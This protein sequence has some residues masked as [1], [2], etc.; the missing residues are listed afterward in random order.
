MKPVLVYDELFGY[1]PEVLELLDA[2]FERVSAPEPAAASDADLARAEVL[3]AHLKH[4]VD[5]ALLDRCPR[6]KV[7]ASS[8]LSVPHVDTAEAARRGVAVV[9]LGGEREFMWKVTPT[10]EVAWGLIIAVTRHM[11]LALK[12]AKARNRAGRGLGSM[13]PHMLSRM[14]LG[15][16]GL[17]RLGTLTAEKAP[18]FGMNVAYYSPHSRDDRF[19]RCETLTELAGSCDVVSL[20]AHHTPETTGMIGAD[21]FRAMR[22]GGVLI[23]TA[24]GELVDE[25]ALLDALESGHLAGAGLDVISGEHTPGFLERLPGHPLLAYA[26]AHDNL[27]VTPHYAGATRDAWA[28]TQTRTVE[29]VLAALGDPGAVGRWSEAG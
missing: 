10:V 4:P 6:L 13:T 22:P 5:R 7:I 19:R 21:F 25:A 27:I 14:T 2:R 17:G 20:H 3:L 12:Q 8:T 15:I 24:R 26:R 9:H 11:P 16:V 18:A 29:L 1:L 23:N 28:L